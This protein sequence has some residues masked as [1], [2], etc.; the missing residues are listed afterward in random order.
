MAIASEWDRVTFDLAANDIAAPSVFFGT[1]TA[2]D[3]RWMGRIA[4]FAG[5]GSA[6]LACLLAAD[7][8]STRTAVTATVMTA[9]FVLMYTSFLWPRAGVAA[10]PVVRSQ[11]GH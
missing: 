8:L 4:M 7:A 9:V 5:S 11:N 3:R 6:T 2:N 10:L 1:K